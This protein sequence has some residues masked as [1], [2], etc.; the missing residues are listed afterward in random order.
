[1]N[2]G[3]VKI[4]RKITQWAWYKDESVARVFIHL[5]ILAN[6]KDNAWR[7]ITVKRGQLVT[8]YR[9]LAE[10]LGIGVATVHRAIK[11][12]ISTG[13]IATERNAK[14]TIITLINY[15]QYQDSGTIA[16]QKRN[17]SGTI[18]ESNKNDKNDKNE[19]KDIAP[20]AKTESGGWKARKKF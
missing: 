7:N 5:L 19:K 1:M 10:E 3:F 20:A 2:E 4:H 14:Y 17:D 9:H 16:E 18:A 6:H 15:I 11:K 8:S 12:L 13:E